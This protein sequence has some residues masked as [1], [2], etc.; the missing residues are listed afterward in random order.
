MRN[1]VSFSAAQMTTAAR[2]GRA[3]GV[4]GLRRSLAALAGSGG[5]AL[6]GLASFA[7]I[8]AFAESC[9]NEAFRT[10]PSANLPD[11][12]AY[13]EVTPAN[14][15]GSIDSFAFGDD[16]DGAIPAS[17]GERI[18]VRL[19]FAKFEPNP[20]SG[21]AVLGGELAGSSYVFSRGASGWQMTSVYPEGS[22]QTSYLPE[23]FNP[24]L[25]EIGVA[26]LTSRTGLEPGPE[27]SFGVGVPGGPYR[28]IATTPTPEQQLERTKEGLEGAS[29]D[30][31]HIVLHSVDRAL[32]SAEPE[33]IVAAGTVPGALNLY[34]SFEGRL[35]LVNL[36]TAGALVSS[37]GAVLD[38]GEEDSSVSTAH[39][40]VSENG[41]KIFFTAPEHEG[42]SFE[43]SCQEPVR[44]YMRVDGSKTDEVSE[45]APGVHP[46]EQQPVD[47]DGAS[48]D[49]SKVFFNTTMQ[50]TKDAHGG[51]GDRELY[52]Y[53]TEAPEGE[54]LKRISRGEE[55]TTLSSAEGNVPVELGEGVDTVISENGSTVYFLAGGKLTPN[56]PLHPGNPSLYRYNTDDGSIRY[57]AS[58]GPTAGQSE[59]MYTTPN[60][61]SLLFPSDGV[62]GEPRGAGHNEL[63]RYD[64]ADGS[65]MCV[66]CGLGKAPAEGQEI[67]PSNVNG[68]LETRAGIPA[69]IPMSN[70]G[71]Y[72]FFQTTARLVPLDTN[73][74]EVGR[75]HDPGL[76]VYE[77]ETD[78]TGGCELSQGCTHLISSGESELQT[79]LLGASADGSNV[80]FA[81]H[82]NLV[83][84]DTD[85]YG[86]VYDARIDGGFPAPAP[87]PPP[88]SSCQGVGSPPPLFNV[89]ASGSFFGAP[90][91]VAPVAQAKLKSK[92]KKK[93][94]P[95]RRKRKS[96]AA[97][98]DGGRA[99]TSSEGR[100]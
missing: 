63:Y 81:T 93:P 8:P 86:D 24:E 73:S 26:T 80:F 38:A 20:G 3:P 94:K 19:A 47:Y 96:R 27:Q 60:G 70:D 17:D 29:A 46:A 95:M 14:K 50:L 32:A 35:R 97:R 54:R 66:S 12:R 72:V 23:L 76:D 42:P 4:R 16:K 39:R 5:L 57:I 78:G 83:A 51:S 28:P 52:E 71:S 45:P 48:V 43:A 56:A 75:Q 6:A 98:R 84:Q 36:T 100:R 49:G 68:V 7:V 11:C 67:T 89:P 44:L 40:A 9:P 65:V 82:A 77:W 34:E 69:L 88:C 85:T 92:S 15:G 99:R 25:T 21:G 33:R 41:S 90:N 79:E 62:V 1:S 18:A 37:C 58:V 87:P 55:G 53:D 74:T 59:A 22:G 30:L 2:C 61:K 10:G 31:S 64:N 91:P 13:E